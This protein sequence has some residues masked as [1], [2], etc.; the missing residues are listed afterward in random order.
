MHAAYLDVSVDY[1]KGRKPENAE[2]NPQSTWEINNS[3]RISS[4]FDNQHGTI[5]AQVVTHPVIIPFDWA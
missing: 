4:K 3:T 5:Y 2:K 1:T